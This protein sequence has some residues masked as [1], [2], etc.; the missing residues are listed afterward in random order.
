[1]DKRIR[2]FLKFIRKLKNYKSSQKPQ[3]LNWVL[4]LLNL[5]AQNKLGENK[6]KSIKVNL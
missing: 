3:H 6:L 4:L 1:M 2:T 5:K